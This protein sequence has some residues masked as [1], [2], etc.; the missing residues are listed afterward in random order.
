MV[1]YNVCNIFFSR[2]IH[3]HIL[4]V[5]CSLISDLKKQL[6]SDNFFSL[7]LL[8]ALL[9]SCETKGKWLHALIWLLKKPTNEFISENSFFLVWTFLIPVT[10]SLGQVS[11]EEINY[12]Y[13]LLFT[14]SKAA[15]LK[16]KFFWLLG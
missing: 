4:R 12:D 5:Y 6:K 10:T 16:K 14:F 2:N 9:T 3:T 8:W 15:I 11:D 1:H 7:K 13:E